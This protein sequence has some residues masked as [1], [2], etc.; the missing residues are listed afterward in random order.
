[1]YL[2]T[3]S[4]GE[5]AFSAFGHNAL[6]VKD[7][8]REVDL[9]FAFGA[10]ADSP[11]LLTRFL[12]GEA[13][14]ILI[15]RNLENTLALYQRDERRVSA[16]VLNLPSSTALSLEKRLRELAQP[17]NRAYRY[18]WFENN[19][20]TRIRDLLDESTQGALQEAGRGQSGQTQRDEILRH[21]QYSLHLWFS[22]EYALSGDVERPM[23]DWQRAFIPSELARLTQHTVLQTESGET[24]ALASA[25]CVLLEGGA[26]EL[27][28]PPAM[29]ALRA[30]L[31]SLL[32]ALAVA[33]LANKGKARALAMVLMS[34]FYAGLF[35]LGTVSA[36]IWA[37]GGLQALS[38][39]LNLV[40]ASP[41]SV[42]GF[43]IVFGFSR[44]PRARFALALAF[45]FAS[46][47]GLIAVVLGLSAL[48]SGTFAA[49]ALPFH[50]AVAWRCWRLWR[51]ELVTRQ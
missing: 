40:H 20:S 29:P 31:L 32:P 44:A 23:S 27:E 22:L 51:A 39:N 6:Y 14:A 17:E 24:R 37:S 30:F 18:H 43:A 12:L 7:D 34:L 48:S 10:F 4:P 47:L 25:P 8:A 36:L 9:V 46:L 50:L 49:F 41:A 35:A 19:C 16:Q 13:D 1:M 28:T 5:S 15:V 38:Q 21:V 45:A 42:L 33:F 26:A 2:L 11:S 3:M